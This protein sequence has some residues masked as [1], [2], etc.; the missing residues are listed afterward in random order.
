MGLIKAAIGAVGGTLADSWKEAIHCPS[1]DN[2]TLLKV[3]TKMSDGSSRTSNTKGTSNYISNGS[4]IMVETGTCMLTLDNGK[5]TNI[6]TEPGRYILDNSTAPSIFAGQI[7]DSLKD[8]LS[9][10][11]YG[12]TPA[13]EQKVVYINLQEIPNLLFGTSEPMPYFDPYYNTSIELKCF[14]TFS[15]QI[16]DAEAAVRFYTEVCPKGVN[17]GDLTAQEVFGTDQYKGEFMQALLG[18]LSALSDQGVMYAKIQTKLPQLAQE[19]SRN[20]VDWTE[21]GFRIKSVAFRGPVTLSED[22]KKRLGARLEADTQLDPNVQRAMMNK[23]IANGIEAMGSNPGNGGGMMGV[24]GMG[25]M[26]NMGANL[27]NSYPTQ[28]QQPQPQPTIQAQP[29]PAAQAG[30]K[31]P[32]CGAVGNT[33][34]FCS[35]CGKPQPVAPETWVCASCGSTNTT[36]FC[37]NCGAK[38]GAQKAAAASPAEWKCGCG[39]TNTTKFCSNCGKPKPAAPKKYKCDK[40]GW[41][42]PDPEKPPKFCP[43]CGDAFDENDI[44]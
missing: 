11:T 30:W 24:M 41:T 43:E 5:I 9:R 13:A 35:S 31:C 39:A 23:G 15:I 7:K 8:V 42:P 21:R 38:K 28:P 37:T 6:V 19:A 17:A 1:I 29:A 14:G 10:F 25:Q 4:A 36:N 26:M 44:V 40:C 34:K 22:S 20:A 3:G 33:G 12:G 2:K 16:P 32:E 18:G 27:L